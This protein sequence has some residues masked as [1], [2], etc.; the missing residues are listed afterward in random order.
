MRFL[1]SI[2]AR[3]R[4]RL[5]SGFRGV[6]ALRLSLVFCLLA[7]SPIEEDSFMPFELNGRV[8]VG[9]DFC[10]RSTQEQNTVLATQLGHVRVNRASLVPGQPPNFRQLALA[11]DYARMFLVPHH[12][13]EEDQR[14]LSISWWQRKEQC[15]GHRVLTELVAQIANDL[16][17]TE[18]LVLDQLAHIGLLDVRSGL[19]SVATEKN[20]ITTVPH[21][22]LAT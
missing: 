18:L 1:D 15:P 4:Q 22:R 12:L 11:R 10:A 16:L 6:P 20:P 9:A 14:V 2:F 17:C 5:L 7:L 13:L 3:D 8:Y 21:L 19:V